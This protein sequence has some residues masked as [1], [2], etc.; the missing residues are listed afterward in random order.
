M[1]FRLF[2]MAM[3]GVALASCVNDEVN[4]VQEEKKVKIAFET[5]V[6]YN[7]SESR[8]NVFG[9]IGSHQYTNAGVIYSYPKDESFIIYAVAHEGRFDG[10]KA[11]EEYAFNGFAIS[12]DQALDGWAPKTPAGDP[13][14]EGKYYFWPTSKLMTFAATS[15]ADLAVNGAT[16]SYD[17]T[18]LKINDFEV[19]GDASKQYDLLFSQRSCN[20][21]S[22]DML[23]SASY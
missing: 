13:Q 21:S 9:E 7:N 12:H 20:R 15:P 10:W 16:R 8:A 1:K 4:Q 18:G 17:A 5:P 22:V 3:A 23:H 2:L 11:D 14:G 19:A 6:L